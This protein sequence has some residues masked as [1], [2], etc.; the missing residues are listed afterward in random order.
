MHRYVLKIWDSEGEQ[1]KLRLFTHNNL[2]RNF[3][4]GKLQKEDLLFIQKKQIKLSIPDHGVLHPPQILIGC[5]QLCNFI[6][7]GTPHFTM[8]SGL[9]L[10]P[11]RL[12]YMVS[13]E[14]LNST[15][16][17][18]HL[19][20]TVHTV[21]LEN[22]SDL[23]ETHWNVHTQALEQE[24]SGPEKEEKAR[25][26]EQVLNKFKGTVEKRG[27]GYVIRLPFEERHDHLPDNGA[28]VLR[29]LM[30]ILRKYEE[31]PIILKQY[32]GVFQDQLSKGIL[33]EVDETEDTTGKP[34]HYLPH[35]PV[36]T[37]QKDTTEF[38]IVFDASAHYKNCPSLNDV[39]HQG[40]TVLPKLYGCFY[41]FELGSASY[42]SD[43]EKAFLQVHRHEDDRDFT[44]CLW[45]KDVMKPLTEDN[46]AVYRFRRVTFGINA[47]PFLL[48]ATIHFHLDNYDN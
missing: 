8:P 44:R 40:L 34:K 18:Q 25:I 46:L 38:R 14:R 6:K 45:I 28:P 48:S 17:E 3:T 27:I 9:I 4:G 7:F 1:H 12:G 20:S 31:E 19:N 2:T 32:H 15:N 30:S 21:E 29:R 43:V 37:P 23:W 42:L 26:N 13:G 41:A 39:V 22:G 33:E 11:T 5:D 47:S 24:Y 35:Q 16:T 10:V 36:I